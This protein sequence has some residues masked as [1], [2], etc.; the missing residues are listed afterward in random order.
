MSAHQVEQAVRVVKGGSRNRHMGRAGHEGQA[1]FAEPQDETR[2]G[3][4]QNPI[5]ALNFMRGDMAQRHVHAGVVLDHH[6]LGHSGGSGCE[7]NRGQI[8]PV[9]DRDGTTLLPVAILGQGLGPDNRLG[10]V[11][12]PQAGQGIE[13]RLRRLEAVKGDQ[14]PDAGLPREVRQPFGGQVRDHRHVHAAGLQDSQK[15]LRQMRRS[16]HQNSDC[17]PNADAAG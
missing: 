13:E 12:A 1:K 3:G 6:P 5:P 10:Y 2:R 7:Q 11:G 16:F 17:L 4:K 15:G 9:A 14:L 8:G